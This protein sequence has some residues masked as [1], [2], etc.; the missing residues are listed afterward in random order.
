MLSGNVWPL[1]AE[2]LVYGPG[3]AMLLGFWGA[4]G[5]SEMAPGSHM[6]SQA[7]AS[8]P[9]LHSQCECT[10]YAEETD[11]GC[12]DITIEASGEMVHSGAQVFRLSVPPEKKLEVLGLAS[13]SLD[14]KASGKVSS[15]LLLGQENCHRQS[16]H[17][18]DKCKSKP[19]GVLIITGQLRP[20]RHTWD[21]C[22]GGEGS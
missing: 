14:E 3:Q 20:I 6:H 17:L 13:L 9:P 22:T 18:G 21:P 10:L 19:Q 12:S 16:L 11:S 8:V 4:G 15:S 5:I 2:S 1:R 7:L